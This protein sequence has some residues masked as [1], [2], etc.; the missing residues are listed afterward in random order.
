[1]DDVTSVEDLGSVLSKLI[2]G[3][4]TSLSYEAYGRFFPP[5]PVSA[6]SRTYCEYVARSRGCRVHDVPAEKKIWFF[7]L[8]GHTIPAG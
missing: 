5:G 1:L 3:E 7:K 2:E 8:P 6:T 4:C